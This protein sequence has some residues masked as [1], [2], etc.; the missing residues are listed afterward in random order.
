MKN[1]IAEPSTPK[2][3]IPNT[4]DTIKIIY[5]RRAVRKYKDISV[6]KNLIEQIIDTGRM[7]PSAINKQPWKFYGLILD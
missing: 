1:I 2:S 5:E 4:N 3:A 7:A 6:E